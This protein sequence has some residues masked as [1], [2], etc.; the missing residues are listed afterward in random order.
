MSVFSYQTGLPIGHKA[1]IG[2][3]VLQTDETIENDFRRILPTDGVAFYA[4]RVPSAPDVST[5]TLAQMEHELPAAAA[6]LPP[7]VKFDAVGYGCTSGTSVIGAARIAELVRSGCSTK[8]V[9]EPV[10]GLIAAC[11]NLGVKRIAFLSPYVETVSA[12]LRGVLGDAGVSSPVFGSFNEASEAKVAQIDG[13]SIINAA[14][15]LAAGQN[16]DAIFL[17][18]TNLRTLDVITDIEAKTGLPVLSSNQ[19]LIWHL[20]RLAGQT[21][22]LPQFGRLFS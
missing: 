22:K 20:L 6:L 3:I 9:S 19:V 11:A 12:R 15:A 14:T 1:T 7:P 4:S 10:S 16:V 18:C 5:E 21:V 13:A 17:S 8:E 2:L